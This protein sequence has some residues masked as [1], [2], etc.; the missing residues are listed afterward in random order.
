MRIKK[1]N[2]VTDVGIANL[3]T[4]DNVLDVASCQES[5]L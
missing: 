3:T 5:I 1:E 4:I 2:V